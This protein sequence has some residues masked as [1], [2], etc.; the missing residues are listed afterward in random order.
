[1]GA[2]PASMR[3]DIL[4]ARGFRAGQIGVAMQRPDEPGTLHP[5]AYV[6]DDWR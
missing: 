1:M 5:D 4:L 2:F 3:R 6:I